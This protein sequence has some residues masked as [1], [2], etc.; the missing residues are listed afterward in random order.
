MH[1]AH[2]LEAWV[3]VSA[4]GSPSSNSYTY[5]YNEKLNR[6]SY[7]FFQPLPTSWL[8]ARRPP[9]SVHRRSDPK[10]TFRGEKEKR[11]KRRRKKKN[12]MS[13]VASL[14]VSVITS[15]PEASFTPEPSCTR[16][17][18]YAIFSEGSCGNVP[19]RY[20]HLGPTTSAEECMPSG[21][22]DEEDYFQS[23]GACPGGYTIACAQSDAD[24]RETTATCCPR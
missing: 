12:T 4:S 5:T 6:G 24:S 21:W 8:P 1:G 7:F 3:I 18:Y 13:N 17:I 2:P 10:S 11:E 9:D 23:P 20:F 15:A 14:P 19:C 22:E 16:D